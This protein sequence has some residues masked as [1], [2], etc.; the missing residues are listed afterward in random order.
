VQTLVLSGI[1]R[2]SYG[3]LRIKIW[4]KQDKGLVKNGKETEKSGPLLWKN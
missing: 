3:I 1:A 4:K 2:F